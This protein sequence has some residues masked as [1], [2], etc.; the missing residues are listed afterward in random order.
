[1]CGDILKDIVLNGCI[2]HLLFI[3]KAT[4]CSAIDLLVAGYASTASAACSI[5]RQLHANKHVLVKVRKELKD[6]NMTQAGSPLTLQDMNQLKY[7]SS[8]VKETL[9]MSPPIGA[10]FRKA[11]RTFELDVSIYV[12]LL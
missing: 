5:I 8:V 4:V 6:H 7:V 10:A 11:L 3:L 2:F 9:R 12:L 1:M